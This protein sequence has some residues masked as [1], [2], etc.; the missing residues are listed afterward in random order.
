MTLQP[1]PMASWHALMCSDPCSCHV[2]SVHDPRHSFHPE[3]AEP[4][5]ASQRMQTHRSTGQMACHTVADRASAWLSV[6]APGGRLLLLAGSELALSASI[7]ASA[8]T[9]AAPSMRATM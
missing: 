5:P 3:H 6:S 4:G 7:T 9:G 2:Q 8:S 1:H